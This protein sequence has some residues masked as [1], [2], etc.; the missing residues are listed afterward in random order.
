MN[1]TKIYTDT[2]ALRC[3][4][5]AKY[6]GFP[7]EVVFFNLAKIGEYQAKFDYAL[8]NESAE[9]LK[10]YSEMLSFYRDDIQNILDAFANKVLDTGY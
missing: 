7:F 10:V 8:E 4:R 6:P 3:A 2:L 1:N 9:M 5:L